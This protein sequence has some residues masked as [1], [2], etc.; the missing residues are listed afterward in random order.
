MPSPRV[1]SN[2]DA[3]TWKVKLSASEIEW[4]LRLAHQWMST[5][6]VNQCKTHL[7]ERLDVSN[8][9]D[10]M[11]LADTLSMEEL[12]A[13][14]VVFASRAF[15]RIPQQDVEHLAST[16]PMLLVEMLR[17]LSEDIRTHPPGSSAVVR[18]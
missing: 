3:T 14:A 5:E 11:L 1:H 12:C 8:C 2:D 4:A 7:A 10:V 16:K 18:N 13:E 9:V 15:A 17:A 6:M